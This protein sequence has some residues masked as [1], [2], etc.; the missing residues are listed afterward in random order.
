MGLEQRHHDRSDVGTDAFDGAVGDADDVS[1]FDRVA[2]SVFCILDRLGDLAGLHVSERLRHGFDVGFEIGL[3]I[4]PEKRRERLR[5]ALGGH[6]G[7][8]V[9]PKRLRMPGMP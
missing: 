5:N 3:G 2:V 7:A 6:D 8:G 9:S 4:E 1:V